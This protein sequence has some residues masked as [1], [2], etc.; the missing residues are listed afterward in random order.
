MVLYNQD[1]YASIS[2]GSLRSARL[3]IPLV[4][5]FIQPGSVIDVGCGQGIWLAVF[6]ELG[7]PEIYGVDGPWVDKNNLLV[8]REFFLEFDVNEPLALDR[9]FD[10]VVSL[11]VA[12]H[13]P[14][15]NAETLVKSLVKLGPVIL[16]SAAIPFQG[17]TDHKNE[18]WPAYWS[19]LFLAEGYVTIDC[20]RNKLWDN[21][22]V[23]YWY[24]QNIL[25][26]VKY[27]KISDYAALN[28]EFMGNI[29][30]PLSVVHPL[31]YLKL[32]EYA[33]AELPESINSA[34]Q[35][36]TIM[37]TIRLLFTKLRQR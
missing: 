2:Q 9:Q 24:R 18:Q 36:L 13:L 23:E 16:F 35:N 21:N 12:E 19:R 17:G 5:K 32:R 7:V 8:N 27:D 3:V 10:L 6:K 4:L 30:A 20:L 25:F 22:D 33:D 1:F 15:E 26:F 11:E 14:R 29:P 28:Q 34:L 31:C 37:Q